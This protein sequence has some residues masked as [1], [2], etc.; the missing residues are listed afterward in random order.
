MINMGNKEIT[1]IY[2]GK[3]AVNGI[4]CGQT[5]IWPTTISNDEW[6][7]G[8]ITDSQGQVFD[9][10]FKK[11]LDEESEIDFNLTMLNGIEIDPDASPIY[12]GITHFNGK[13]TCL[14]FRTWEEFD[15][16]IT[17]RNATIFNFTISQ[18]MKSMTF[19]LTRTSTDPTI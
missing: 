14:N 11:K 18:G 16:G 15:T 2:C 3:N 5:L 17:D 4:Y 13:W 8:T 12:F 7:T 6:L 1:S 9:A 19:I 10:I